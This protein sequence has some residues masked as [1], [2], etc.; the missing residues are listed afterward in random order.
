MR[1]LHKLEVQSSTGQVFTIKGRDLPQTFV[2]YTG[3]SHEGNLGQIILRPKAAAAA[4]V[5]TKTIVGF[6]R[7][8]FST[9]IDTSPDT[10]WPTSRDAIQM[11][12][13]FAFACFLNFMATATM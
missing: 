1:Q 4:T 2:T 7:K 5:E 11:F 13:G 12:I 10:R 3:I 9:V 6:G 8:P